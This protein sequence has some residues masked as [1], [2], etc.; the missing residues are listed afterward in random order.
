MHTRA[1]DDEKIYFH[2]NQD[3]SGDV[4]INVPSDRVQRL[5][6]E[7]YDLYSVEVPGEVLIE[8]IGRWLLDERISV[9]EEVEDVK[10]FLTEG[11]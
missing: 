4:I 8:F 3:L 6:P 10:A 9:L 7:R 11:R 5:N 2:H 1:F